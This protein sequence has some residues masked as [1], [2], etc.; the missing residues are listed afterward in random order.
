MND[1]NSLKIVVL[2]G[3]E[4]NI[5][6]NYCP[7]WSWF[8]QSSWLSRYSFLARQGFS[9]IQQRVY[10]KSKIFYW[11][12]ASMYDIEVFSA[13]K[14]IENVIIHT[15][16]SFI[17]KY[18]GILGKTPLTRCSLFFFFDISPWLRLGKQTV[19]KAV[20]M[21]KIHQKR[22]DFKEQQRVDPQLWP[23]LILNT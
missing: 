22:P 21:G 12:N 6:L 11:I 20:E 13:S 23:N 7:K 17:W 19:H 16:L 8:V 9:N 18:C 10:L 4:S 3:T 5:F 2:R 15:S 1:K 14:D